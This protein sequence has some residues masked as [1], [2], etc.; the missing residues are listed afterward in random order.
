MAG[1]NRSSVSKR[2]AAANL[3]ALDQDHIGALLG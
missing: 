2:S 1:R 3:V